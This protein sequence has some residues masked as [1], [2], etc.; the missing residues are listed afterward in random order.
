MIYSEDG[1]SLH[2]GDALKQNKCKNEG[3]D[4]G[5]WQR[6]CMVGAGRRAQ[7]GLMT[8]V[9]TSVMNHIPNYASEIVHMTIWQLHKIHWCHHW[10]I[11]SINIMTLYCY[12]NI[13]NFNSWC[14]GLTV[15][16]L[17]WLFLIFPVAQ[18][19]QGIVSKVATLFLEKGI[20]RLGTL[21]R[22]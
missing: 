5:F 18:G 22:T 16:L 11:D 8:K 6:S 3:A 13:S 2:R 20:Y 17:F 9:M 4:F 1:W 15:K 12:D 7:P 14:Q 19:L 21:L 10:I